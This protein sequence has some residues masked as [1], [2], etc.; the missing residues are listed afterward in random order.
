VNENF[1]GTKKNLIY[2]IENFQKQFKKIHQTS[3]KIA[4]AQVDNSISDILE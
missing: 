1:D 3:A 2:Y 4:T